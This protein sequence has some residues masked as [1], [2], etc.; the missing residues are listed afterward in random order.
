VW[1]K[2][3]SSREK[4]GTPCTLEMHNEVGMEGGRARKWMVHLLGDEY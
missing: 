1:G 2:V 3:E 4:G